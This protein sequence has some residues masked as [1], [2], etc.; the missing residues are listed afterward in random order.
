MYNLPVQGNLLRDREF[1]QI[2]TNH[3]RLDFDLVEFLARVD[4]DDATNHFWDNDHVSKMR[5]DEVWLLIW[6]CLLL[7]LPQLLDQS[8]RLAL[9]TTVEPTAS[10]SVNDITELVG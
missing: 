7:G 1:S 5:L 6:S 2:V 10:T 9:E 8:H 4:T 3:L